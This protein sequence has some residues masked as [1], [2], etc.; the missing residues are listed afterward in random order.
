MSSSEKLMMSKSTR[1]RQR[2]KA[3]R[4]ASLML[5]NDPQNDSSIIHQIYPKLQLFE[6]FENDSVQINN[7]NEIN[8]AN[9]TSKESSIT[10]SSDSYSSESD[11]MKFLNLKIYLM[12]RYN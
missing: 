6:N 7:F 9:Y 8:N 3:A 12:Q 1:Y 5:I 2:V 4:L 10:M 11:A